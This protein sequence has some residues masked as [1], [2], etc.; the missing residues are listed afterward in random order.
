[1]GAAGEGA[2]VGAAGVD[3]VVQ[4]GRRKMI[5]IMGRKYLSIGIFFGMICLIL[6]GRNDYIRNGFRL[7]KK[8]KGHCS[9][10]YPHV[11]QPVGSAVRFCH[12]KREG[13]GRGWRHSAK[14]QTFP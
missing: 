2:V 9:K 13:L 8:K 4:V 1:L 7:S 3:G 10:V 14:I 11:S 6:S 12:N 5:R